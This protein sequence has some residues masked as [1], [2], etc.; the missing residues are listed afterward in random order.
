MLG[1]MDGQRFGR[2]VRALRH[3]L[4]WRQ[5]DLAVRCGM[6]QAAVSRLER[7]V[8]GG[9]AMDVLERVTGALG[10]ELEVR[11]RWRGEELDRLLD[12]AH[13]TIVD[14]L[15]EILSDLGWECAPE[16][17]FWIRGER[18]SIDLLA[19]HPPTGRLLVV[20]V[21]TVVPDIQQML[22]SLD[23]KVR[24]AGSIAA[25]RGWRAEG[26]ARAVVLPA[27]S[28]NRRRVERFGAT[29]RA[30]LPADGTAMRRWLA[31]P[32]RPCPGA[33]WFLSD[34]RVMTAVR[35]RRVRLRRGRAAA[36]G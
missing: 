19:W 35:R 29:M 36:G 2:S 30:A 15:I 5:S 7:G 17:T 23:R 31:D 14:R 13:A 26:V 3:R 9:V 10:A 12:A 1:S 24:L 8:V 34:S 11:V 21:K 25:R 28:T 33:L 6:S 20:E 22:G 18:G 16:A 4:G 27:T 32:V